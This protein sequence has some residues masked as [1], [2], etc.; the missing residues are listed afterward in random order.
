MNQNTELPRKNIFQTKNQTIFP[1]KILAEI[2]IFVAMGG[3]LAYV[4]HSFFSLPQGG[5]INLGMVPIF[6]LALR[7][8]PKIGIFAGA[9]LGVVDLAI[10]PFVVHPIQ[11][12]LDY[13]LAFACL[14]LAGLF[15]KFSRV[16]PVVGVAVGG[17]GRFLCHF[18][19]GVVYFA[20]YAP[21]GVS[22]IVYSIVYNGTYMVPSIII[23]AVAIVLLQKSKTLNIYI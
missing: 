16:G 23:C 11:F 5:S 13:P 19:S 9:V 18:I 6:W 1:T 14:G 7:R 20:N 15:R 4:A 22:P 21:E 10:E 2:I 17:V 8:G 12:L 3:A